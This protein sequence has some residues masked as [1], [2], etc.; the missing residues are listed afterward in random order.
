MFENRSDFQQLFNIQDPHSKF[1]PINPI[2]SFVTVKTGKTFIEFTL[3]SSNIRCEA[4]NLETS[5]QLDSDFIQ[6]GKK[7][8]GVH[9]YHYLVAVDF[10]NDGQYELNIIHKNYQGEYVKITSYQFWVSGSEDN[11]V[12]SLLDHIDQ[13]NEFER[14][15]NVYNDNFK[16]IPIQPRAPFSSISNGFLEIDFKVS[17]Q[18][19]IIHYNIINIENQ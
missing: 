13:N 7:L 6:I 18:V 3:D 5:D 16:F 11:Y 4:I 10:K 17:N 9:D 1:V 2:V 14:L 19:S 15:F 12:F 8:S